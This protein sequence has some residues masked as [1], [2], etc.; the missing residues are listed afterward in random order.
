MTPRTSSAPTRTSQQPGADDDQAGSIRHRDRHLHALRSPWTP[1]RARL[2]DTCVRATA[3]FNHRLGIVATPLPTTTRTVTCPTG[4]GSDARPVRVQVNDVDTYLTDSQQFLLEYGVRIN[5]RGCYSIC[6]SFRADVPDRTHLTEFLHSEAEIP[7]D[8]AD[9]IAHVES[10]VR[11]LSAAILDECG[12]ELSAVTEDVSH[13]E[14]LAARDEPFARLTFDEAITLLDT[15]HHV[16]TDRNGSRHLTRDGERRL[17]EVVDEF[18]WVS[19]FDHL[20]VPFY[21]GFDGDGTALAA[22]LFFGPGEVVGSGQRHTTGDQLREALRTHGV[23]EADYA[24]YIRMKDEFPVTTSGF[25]FGVERF[26]LWVL[27]H[28]DI[29]DIPLIPRHDELAAWPPTI[30]RP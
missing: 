12:A 18:T 6:P 27:G 15:E 2:Y 17:L 20:A 13:L 30:D 7:G 25:G 26:L 5:P 16:R 11:F 9:L 8:L 22:D 24:W 3:T 10:Y 1:L 21:H 28:D 29:R 23:P 4:L 19:H 14:R